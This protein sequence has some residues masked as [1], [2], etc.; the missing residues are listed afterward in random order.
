MT[1]SLTDGLDADGLELVLDEY[2]KDTF[3]NHVV[4]G[5]AQLA[6]CRTL[7]KSFRDAAAA[8]RTVYDAD[9]EYEAYGRTTVPVRFRGGL[10]LGDSHPATSMENEYGH[11]IRGPALAVIRDKRTS[12][13]FVVTSSEVKFV[14]A[15][16][17][18]S[19]WCVIGRIYVVAQLAQLLGGH[20][21]L[22]APPS[23]PA[24]GGVQLRGGGPRALDAV[25]LDH[26]RRPRF[27][28]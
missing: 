22:V 19:W 23:Q 18:S 20:L 21:R 14:C 24:R 16:V 4:P 26:A 5:L 25:P 13:M 10:W 28:L 7:C 2:A 12:R 9:I 17:D 3:G 6:K 11:E 1:V 15:G 8:I 27:G